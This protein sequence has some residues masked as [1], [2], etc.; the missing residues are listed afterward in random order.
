MTVVRVRLVQMKIGYHI[1]NSINAD[2]KKKQSENGDSIAAKQGEER[3]R[4]RSKKEDSI[5]LYF[6]RQGRRQ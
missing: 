3:K 6:R 5:D 2:Y 1:H 4:T